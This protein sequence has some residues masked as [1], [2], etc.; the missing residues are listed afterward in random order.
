MDYFEKPREILTGKIGILVTQPTRKT[1]KST[2]TAI[3]NE[4]KW[5]SFFYGVYLVT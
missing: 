4:A 2:F 5:S 1:R 3:E